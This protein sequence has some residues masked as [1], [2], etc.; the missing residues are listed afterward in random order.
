M[1]NDRDTIKAAVLAQLRNKGDVYVDEE[2]IHT[3]PRYRITLTVGTGTG[4]RHSRRR[5]YASR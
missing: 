5:H 4:R 2:A 1:D 3:D